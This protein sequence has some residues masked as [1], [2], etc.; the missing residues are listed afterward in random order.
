M[1]RPSAAVANWNTVR[2][3][4]TAVK[5]RMGAPRSSGAYTVETFTTTPAFVAGGTHPQAAVNVSHSD[6]GGLVYLS[7]VRAVVADPLQ[8]ERDAVAGYYGE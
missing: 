4:G 7:G 3:V 8:A 5:V 1:T 2:P 6:C